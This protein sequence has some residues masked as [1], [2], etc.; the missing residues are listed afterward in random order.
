ME[1]GS[2]GRF[3]CFLNLFLKL[4]AEDGRVNAAK[5]E[6]SELEIA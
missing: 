5:L 1:S 4:I 2:I 6:I 3:L